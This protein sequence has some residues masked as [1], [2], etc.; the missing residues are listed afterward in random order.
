MAM[1]ATVEQIFEAADDM[2]VDQADLLR[3]SDE[4]G[5]VIQGGDA[6]VDGSPRARQCTDKPLCGLATVHMM[7]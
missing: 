7:P 2:E 6:E 1:M 3:R 5:A 4:L